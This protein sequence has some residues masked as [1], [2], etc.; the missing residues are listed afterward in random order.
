MRY[1][2]TFYIVLVNGHLYWHNDGYKC[3]GKLSQDTN[4]ET[5]RWFGE[6]ADAVKYIEKYKNE[7]GVQFYTIKKVQLSFKEVEMEG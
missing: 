1:L 3:C 4:M 7:L 6:Y 2:N 5:L